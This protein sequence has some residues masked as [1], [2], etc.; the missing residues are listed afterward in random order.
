MKANDDDPFGR[1]T[2]II[3]K[4]VQIQPMANHSNVFYIYTWF[5]VDSVSVCLNVNI[6][7]C[8]C[9]LARFCACFY[10]TCTAAS[11]VS[12]HCKKKKYL[13]TL[14]YYIFYTLFHRL[15]LYSHTLE[16]HSCVPI[17]LYLRVVARYVFSSIMHIQAYFFCHFYNIYHYY[18]SPL[19]SPWQAGGT[20][21]SVRWVPAM[22]S[23]VACRLFRSNANTAHS[24][25]IFFS[26]FSRVNRKNRYIC[27]YI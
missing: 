6:Y 11:F 8:V 26:R 19:P 18:Y 27:C 14:D 3:A 13:Y 20:F 4:G 7:V 9:V 2:N 24:T 15:I 17:Y 12:K 23:C 22:D 16:I 1:A 25:H 5:I 21:F 10:A